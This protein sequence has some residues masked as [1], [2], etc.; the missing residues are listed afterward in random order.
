M[1]I[2]GSS[3]VKNL[4]VN[5]GDLGSISG[6]GDPLEKGMSTHSSILACGIPWTE[7]TGVR[8]YMGSQKSWTRFRD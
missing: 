8:Q 2:P 1:G 5:A 6:L 7:E 3:V 4:P